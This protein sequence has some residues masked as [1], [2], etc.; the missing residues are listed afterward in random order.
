MSI[1]DNKLVEID[2]TYL[3]NKGFS[4]SSRSKPGLYVIRK[5]KGNH[6]VYIQYYFDHSKRK[7]I[8]IINRIIFNGYK[9][10]LMKVDEVKVTDIFNM[11]LILNK[12][13]K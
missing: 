6:G 2:K 10:T 13:L 5:Q 11:E 7:N 12:Y 4:R 1:F 9:S 8:L 3:L